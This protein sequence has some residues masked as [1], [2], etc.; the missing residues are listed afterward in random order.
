MR[1]LLVILTFLSLNSVHALEIDEKLTLRFLKVSNSKKTVLINRGA[2]DGLAVGDHAKFFITSGVIARGVVEKVSP[3]RSIWSLYRVVE[4][5][6]VTD[7]KVLNLKI[8]S[9]VKITDDPSKSMKDEPIPGG[10]DKMGMND[11]AA[12]E[13]AASKINEDEQKELEGMGLEE[14]A[15][16]AKKEA[17]VKSN[18]SNKSNEPK[19]VSMME[20]APIRG[21]ANTSKNWEVWGTI[22]LNALS[23]TVDNGTTSTT[24]T[25]TETKASSVDLSAG[26]ERYFLAS[27]SFLKNTSLTIF[28][29][30]RTLES[31][32]SDKLGIDWFEFGGGVNYHFYN[33][34]ATTNNIIGFGG[35]NLG[36]GNATISTTTNGVSNSI[37]G[38]NTFFS[39]GVGAKYVLSNGFGVRALFDYYSSNESY[40]V[41]AVTSTRKLS[42]PRVLFGIS[43]RF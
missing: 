20:D 11:G 27:D 10:S 3:S 40:T 22:Y 23:G 37:K 24:A 28:V 41:D 25:S 43:Y 2:E 21:G 7:G 17:P 30:K 42:G 19:E 1:V 13:G 35:V 8:A 6:E 5:A 9:P 34:A 15:K 31:S 29:H 16:P 12:E 26:I 32:S 14:S 4:P 39:V 36:A 38:T 18:K 33:S